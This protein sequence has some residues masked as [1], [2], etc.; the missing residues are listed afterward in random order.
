VLSVVDDGRLPLP[1]LVNQFV[2][3]GSLVRKYWWGKMP[4]LDRFLSKLV[5]SITG[6]DRELVEVC[7]EE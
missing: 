6:N 2:N 3:A 7:N 1:S 4:G 5:M